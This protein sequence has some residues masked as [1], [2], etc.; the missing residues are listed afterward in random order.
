MLNKLKEFYDRKNAQNKTRLIWKLFN[1]IYKDDD[2][3]PE[4]M[5]VLRLLRVT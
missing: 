2:S 3:M 4:N 5:N 1:M